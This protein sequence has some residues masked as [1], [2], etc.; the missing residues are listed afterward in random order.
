MKRILFSAFLV[1]FFGIQLFTQTTEH[2]LQITVN[3][4]SDLEILTRMVSID[5]INGNE[6]IAYAN[7]KELEKLKTTHFKFV[8]LEHPSVKASRAITMATTVAE[9]SNWDRYPTYSVYNQL[10]VKFTNDYPNLCKLDT[11]GTSISNRNILV[12]NISADINTPQ[13]K[14]EV[15]F[16]STI[17]GDETTGWILCLRLADYLLSNYGTNNRI[18]N[19]LNSIS[20]FIAPN[21][22]PD[23]TYRPNDNSIT[24]ATRSNNNGADLNRDYPDPRIGQNTPWQKET[25][26]MMDYAGTRN[27]ILG[28]NYHG[29]AEVAN[30]PW[31]TWASYSKTHA[32]N[33]WFYQISLQYANLAK[34]NG[35]S[36]YFTSVHNSGVTNG[37]DWYVITGGRQDYMNYW[38]NCR[39]ITLEV[40]NTKMV[41]SEQLPNFWNYNR[42]AMLAYI[43]NA[44]YGIRGIV[45]DTDGAPV[46]AKITVV[47]HDKDN[48]HV[49][50]NPQFGNYYRMIQP[51]TYNLLFESYGYVSQTVTGVVAQQNNTT[52]VNVTMYKPTPCIIS[53]V[54]VNAQTGF[55]EP[56]VKIEVKNTPIT[57]IFTD[58]TGN[59]SLEI[60]SGQYQIVFSKNSFA[61]NIQSVVINNDIDDMMITLQLF[62]GIDFENNV[63]PSGFS[64][65]GNMPWYIT[66]TQSYEGARSIRS[67]NI[68]HSQSSTMTY[69]FNAPTGGQVSFYAKVSSEANYDFLKFYIDNVEKGRWSGEVD[70][71][72]FSYD[73]TAGNHTLRWTYEKD[74]S[75]SNGSDAAFVD[76]ISVPKLNQNA[77]PYINPRSIKID[78]EELTDESKIEMWNVGNSVMNYSVSVE[79]QADNLWLSVTD[80]SG[81]LAANQN[82]NIMVMYDFNGL[83]S[84]LYVTNLLIDVIDSVIVIPVEIN[85]IMQNGGFPLITPKSIDIETEEIIG[86]F[87]ISMKNIGNEPFN[88]SIYIDDQTDNWLLFS[89]VQDVLESEQQE[90]FI[91]IYDFTD[92]LYG[93]YTAELKI[94]V[95]DSIITVPVSINYLEKLFG[96]PEITPLYI[97]IET[98]EV[99]GEFIVTMKNIGN[100]QFSYNFYIDEQT[101][102]WLIFTDIQGILE[103][104][105]EQDFTFIYDFTEFL[106]GL[107]SAELKIDVNDSIIIVPV[108]INY[109]EKKVGIPLV[110]PLYIEIETEEIEGNF[111]VTM[112]NI[113][114]KAFSYSAAI[115]PEHLGEWLW[116]TYPDSELEPGETMGFNLFYNFTSMDWNHLYIATLNIDVNDSII[117]IPISINYIENILLPNVN[118]FVIYPNPTSG[119]LRITNYELKEIGE[120]QIFDVFGRNVYTP[121]ETGRAP[122]LQMDISGLPAGIYFLRLQTEKG[123]TTHKIIKQ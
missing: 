55:P 37:G 9:M 7:G 14:P 74:F 30:Y 4:R 106:Y 121:V 123:F 85:F 71:T 102:N 16:S 2:Y 28:I 62:D 107:Y 77:V 8:E 119:E 67:G 25:K 20:I 23:G 70:W 89:D 54:V 27:F 12:L 90:D 79:N 15:L 112:Q 1:L 83:L 115:E 19:M 45:T 88:Y 17:H 46:N 21:T 93:I 75:V 56:N 114:N 116:V 42:E 108:S 111:V 52:I 120:V 29:G 63:V 51:G 48:S 84:G 66:N 24:N 118:Q 32:D 80:N 117:S 87:V 64:F 59:F 82:T 44:N 58:E 38:H 96:I 6:V 13:P 39:E 41:Q 104:E 101:Q 98:E 11:V 10:M 91:F 69:T 103:P 22:N 110:T 109:L 36:D 40:S 33:N 18:T 100:E 35:P 50:S 99:S 61:N 86:E 81:S 65:S 95:I 60:V 43:E 53:G 5:N 122:S 31:D 26:V 68:T 57:P 113:G 34:A 72:E 78:T 97:D 73:I 105:Q 76:L 47:G 92:F 49:F 3:N 94:D